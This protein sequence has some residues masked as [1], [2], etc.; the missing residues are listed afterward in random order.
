MDNLYIGQIILFGGIFA[1]RSTVFCEGQLLSIAQNTALFSILGTTYG[2]DGRTTFG[3]PDLR[4]RVAIQPGTGPGLSTRKL[5]QRSGTETNSL[6]LNQLAA[7]THIATMQNEGSVS[8]PVNTTAG[9]EDEQNPG[10][11]I[12][13]NTGN[14]TYSS[15]SPNGVYGGAAIPVTGASS[16]QVGQT[17]AGQP[18]N[19]MQPFLG[20]NYIICTQGM[21]PSRS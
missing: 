15:S 4:G 21:F 20:L 18:V 9:D 10:V 13:A 16:I 7:H 8:I 14:D 2:G 1:P 3:I 11:G 12:L 5:G 19:N 6:N 17:G